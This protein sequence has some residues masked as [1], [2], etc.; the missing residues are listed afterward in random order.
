MTIIIDKLLSF[1][2][3]ML[4]LRNILFTFIIFLY[5]IARLFL[6]I[7]KLSNFINFII[8][9]TITYTYCQIDS[10]IITTDIGQFI[11]LSIAVYFIFDG[12]KLRE[13]NSYIK[14]FLN[15]NH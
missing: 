6:R 7:P 3:I 8:A 2:L 9:I 14:D 13:R 10:T 1:L 5:G 12:L 4:I 11:L 15:K